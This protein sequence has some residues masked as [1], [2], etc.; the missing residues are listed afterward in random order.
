MKK[1]QAITLDVFLKILIY[2]FSQETNKV[3]GIIR[4]KVR[5]KTEHIIIVLCKQHGIF[6][7]GRQM[8][9]SLL[10][11]NRD[12]TVQWKHPRIRMNE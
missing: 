4:K 6:T 2:T 8:L 12:Y 10:S 5:H 7:S 9:S 3:M 1:H 11:T